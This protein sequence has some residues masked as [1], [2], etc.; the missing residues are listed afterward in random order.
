MADF[1]ASLTS[2]TGVS[3]IQVT[4]D[5]VTI[6]DYSNYLSSTEDG[7]F[8]VNFTLFRKI[9]V[10]DPNNTQYL[11]SSFVGGDQLIS[12]GDSGLNTF[13]GYTLAQIDGVSSFRLITLPTWNSQSQYTIG[14]HVW[15]V[16]D[17]KI[18]KVLADNFNVQ[19]DSDPTKW[20]LVSGKSVV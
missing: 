5:A 15:N 2:P 6:T 8:A 1:Q 3:G 4:D 10:T 7:N 9:I 16:A 13:T 18:Y 19:P 11:F 17:S 20:V 14:D 12:A